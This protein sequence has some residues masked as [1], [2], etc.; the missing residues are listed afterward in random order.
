MQADPNGVTAD[1]PPSLT[2]GAEDFWTPE[3]L[4][5]CG[6]GFCILLIWQIHA[7]GFAALQAAPVRRNRLMG[8][9][10]IVLLSVWLVGMFGFN[11]V[12]TVVF[13]N[14]STVFQQS[15]LYPALMFLEA[16]LIV[17]MLLLA[18]CAF[19][20]R[21][22]GLGLSL[23]TAGR[24]AGWAA[25]YLLA[26]YPLI[27]LGLWA[28]L[29]FGR[30]IRDDFNIEVHQSLTF[31]AENTGWGLRLV[32][33]GFSVLIV[34]V[35]EEML[36]RGFLQTTLRSL[37]HQ[38]PWAAIVLTSALFSLLHPPT[39]VPALFILSC[40][41]GYAY[42]RS[43]SLLRPMFMHIFFNGVSVAATFLTVS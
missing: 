23:R 1:S 35:F 28:V 9:E 8:I 16:A 27:L 17:A 20:R 7:G 30:F 15:L 12:I 22:K 31:L 41:L 10:P 26:V 5:F 33:V 4:M 3:A 34:P 37:T 25:V 14:A 6:I 38:R 29:V 36:F 43:G 40:G 21:L 19:A 32:I 39:H 42:E 18:R 24:D 11:I 2:A 13:K